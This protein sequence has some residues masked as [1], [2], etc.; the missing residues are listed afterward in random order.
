MKK[1]Y[2]IDVD[3]PNCAA[4]MEE[5]ARKTEGVIDAVVNFIA[6]KM[7]VEFAEGV[8]EKEVMELVRRNCR[9]IDSDCEIFV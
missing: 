9:K 7:K 3:C 8:D 4:R 6:L 2:K 5:A 1:S